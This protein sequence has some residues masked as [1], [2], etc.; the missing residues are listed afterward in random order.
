MRTFD[1]QNENQLIQLYIY[2]FCC[3]NSYDSNKKSY[4][5]TQNHHH[6]GHGYRTNKS[7]QSNS[8]KTE[9]THHRSFDK[10][11]SG[12]LTNEIEQASTIRS[13]GKHCI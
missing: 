12:E 3:C 10:M 7:D 4:K 11:K 2:C 6:H 9:E 8:M 13:Q 1:T 5:S